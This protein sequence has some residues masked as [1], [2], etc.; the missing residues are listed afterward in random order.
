M[1]KD[2]MCRG[3]QWLA[4][5][6]TLP[7]FLA[8]CQSSDENKSARKSHEGQAQVTFTKGNPSYSSQGANWK[9]LVVGA[10]V[11]QGD[12]IRTEADDEVDLRFF[13]TGPV[14]R[15]KPSSELKFVK[16]QRWGWATQSPS[17]TQLE[18]IKGRVL[19]DDKKM[20]PG[21]KFEIRTSEGVVYS[22]GGEVK[23]GPPEKSSGDK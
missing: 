7:V 5:L 22:K 9:P 6:A 20:P 8:A 17:M 1:Q 4:L 11:R 16:M 3:G 18:L 10:F 14:A 2:E 19:V 12:A 13:K 23:T 15:L 21:S